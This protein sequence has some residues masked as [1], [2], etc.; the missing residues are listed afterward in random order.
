MADKTIRNW[1]FDQGGNID[2]LLDDMIDSIEIYGL[3]FM[4]SLADL[5]ELA[6]KLPT[7]SLNPLERAKRILWRVVLISRTKPCT[8]NLRLANSMHSK[9]W[10]KK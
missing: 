10:G 3:P 7:S 6:A 2:E 4:S 1:I 8:P 5:S 9:E